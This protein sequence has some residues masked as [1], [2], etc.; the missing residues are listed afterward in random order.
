MVIK[1]ENYEI[2]ITDIG[3]E[4]QGIGKIDNFTLFVE[5]GLP[6]DTL[7]IKV[8][9]L[10]K[11]Y[12]IG[13]LL[14]IVKPSPMRVEPECKVFSLCGGC[15]L[16]HFSYEGQLSYKKNKVYNDLKR[17][18]NLDV[19][20]LDV[21]GMKEPFYYRNKAQFPVR[22]KNDKIEI[23]FF[24]Q[25]SHNVIPIKDCKIQHKINEKIIDIVEKFMIENN[26]MPYD[27]VTHKGIIR[28]ILTKVGFNSGEVMVCIV[29]NAK[30]IPKASTLVDLLLEVEGIKSIVININTQKTNVILSE[31]IEVLWG[32]NFITDSL[33]NINFK[34]SPLSFYQV[35]PV[36][37]KILYEKV[38]EF[39]EF[40][41]DEI[42][43]DA[44]CGIG[45][46]SLFIANKV[47]KVIGIEI[48]PQAI[49]DAKDNALINNIL[50]TE[51]IVGKVEE[52]FL[53]LNEKGLFADVVI[54]DP[55][56]RGCD[57]VLLETI[58][59][60][61]PKKIIYVSCDS[62]TLARDLKFLCETD[63]KILKVQPVDCFCHTTHVETVVMLN[64]IN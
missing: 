54:V 4:G 17:I 49:E 5:G 37:T 47:K 46:I 60:M 57:T 45:T 9:K 15:T 30:K 16:Q 31:K 33:N 7:L 21:I 24:K 10:K 39:A 61:K 38:L 29:I 43:L 2:D 63:Y 62:G 20:V 12:G 36:Q 55:P 18:G 8:I 34:I 50:N 40:S 32:Q 11:T 41:G 53:D 44:Y 48:V 25:R 59:K 19:E 1:N 27:E 42:V 14:N 51:F 64:R 56:R 58:I 13:K 3:S 52:V 22:G 26:V 35:N 6:G 23:G 28:H